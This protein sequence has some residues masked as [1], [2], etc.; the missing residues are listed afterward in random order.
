M[1]DLTLD[2]P[3]RPSLGVANA[4]SLWYPLAKVITPEMPTKGRYADGY[5]RGAIV[6]F[7][8]GHDRD[9]DDAAATI[10][11]GRAQGHAYFCIGPSGRVLQAHPLDRWGHHAGESAWPGLGSS[12]SSKLVGIEICSAGLLDAGG[13]SWFGKTYAKEDIREVKEA[14]WGCPTGRYRKYTEAQEAALVHLLLWL[15]R[16]NEAVFSLNYVLGHHEVS[17]KKGIGRWRKNDPGGALSMTMDQLR[18]KLIAAHEA[19][20]W[21][22]D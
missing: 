4:R 9:D 1:D 22:D 3:L 20:S 11:Y 19:K 2:E 5:P 14:Q 17:G 16:N 10:S 8:A 21:G 18:A 15:K 7:T 12:V 13:R 6:H